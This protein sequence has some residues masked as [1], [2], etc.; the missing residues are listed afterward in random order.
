MIM[1]Y[2]NNDR[3]NQIEPNEIKNGCN[4]ELE[5]VTIAG[6]RTNT[7]ANME[8]SNMI[9]EPD[10]ERD[11]DGSGLCLSLSLFSNGKVKD[12]SEM[13]LKRIF[14]SSVFSLKVSLIQSGSLERK[15]VLSDLTRTKCALKLNHKDKI[16]FYVV[17]CAYL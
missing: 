13:F 16:I 1:T 4:I 2:S 8:L 12:N 15:I 3:M 9:N 17:I 5:L 10:K 6:I 14:I 11:V 7:A